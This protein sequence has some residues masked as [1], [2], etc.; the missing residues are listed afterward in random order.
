LNRTGEKTIT[1]F[2]DNINKFYHFD[3]TADEEQT[4]TATFTVSSAGPLQIR[5]NCFD[6][7]ESN[8]VVLTIK[9]FTV[10][11]KT[12]ET[13]PDENEKDNNETD[14]NDGETSTPDVPQTV[15]AIEYGNNPTVKANQG[16]WY[17]FADGTQ[18]TDYTLYQKP[19]YT[20]DGSLVYALSA[21]TDGKVYQLRYQPDGEIGTE[22]T[23]SFDV[24]YNRAGYILYSGEYKKAEFA[25]AGTQTITYTGTISNDT[26][27]FIQIKNFDAS[28]DDP[29]VLIISNIVVSE[30]VEP[31]V[32]ETPTTPDTPSEN[33]YTLTKGSKDVTIANAGT[34]YYN[35]DKGSDTASWTFVNG[36]PTYKD[37]TI[38]L[39][40]KGG[41]DND[42][43]YL[44]YQPT[45]IAVGGKYTI[46][47]KATV[48]RTSEKA[49]TVTDGT[50]YMHYAATAGEEQTI[51]VTLTVSSSEPLQIRANCFDGT[52]DDP[53]VLTISDVVITP[54]SE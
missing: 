45:D 35:A 7:T 11:P 8:P 41:A 1:V 31:E 18:D 10:T 3:T 27:F 50:T 23:I 32:P 26:P 49:I 46:T 30:Y 44:R 4:I 17:Y 21:M 34:W 53:V 54:V 48:N 29:V 14:N 16:T 24:T 51:T 38:T 22:Y 28:A 43:I 40:Y 20:E 37:G 13:A 19:G 36:D 5:V 39:S 9:D 33:Q 47:F 12:T 6:G 42:K 2:N 52:E 15:T 25:E